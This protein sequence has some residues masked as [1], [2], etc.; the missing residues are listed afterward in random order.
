MLIF[1]LCH[2]HLPFRAETNQMMYEDII[3]GRKRYKVRVNQSIAEL[4]LKLFFS[5]EQVVTGEDVDLSPAPN[6]GPEVR[7]AGDQAGPLV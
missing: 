7:P 3:L 6:P 1:S 4:C 5:V 2:G